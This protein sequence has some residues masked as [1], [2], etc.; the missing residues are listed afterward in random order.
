MVT[1]AIA[2]VI[3][4]LVIPSFGIWLK[5]ARVRS[6]A[7]E[8]AA[9]LQR[10]KSFAVK[11]GHN[12]IGAFNSPTNGSYQIVDDTNNNCVADGGEL[13][14]RTT[15]LPPGV[16]MPSALITLSNNNAAFDSRGLPLGDTGAACL[17]FGAGNGGGTV[18]V[19]MAN[20]SRQYVITLSLAGG[21]TVTGQ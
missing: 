10:A 17:P 5:T 12:V 2:S 13:I 15:S 8:L 3:L 1:L 18:T 6:G 21:V 11:R 19:Q 14:L 9:G 4:S 20:H 7:F 16:V